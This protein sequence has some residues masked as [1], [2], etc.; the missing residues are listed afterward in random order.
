[1]RMVD[2]VHAQGVRVVVDRDMHVLAGGL[3]V[4]GGPATAASEDVNDD[5]G[6]QAEDELRRQ[7]AASFRVG[8]AAWARRAFIAS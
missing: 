5:L 6:A 1:M 7:H 4:G 8:V 3:L 2:L